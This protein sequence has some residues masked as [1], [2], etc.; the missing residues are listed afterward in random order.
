MV[1]VED[2]RLSQLC[3]QLMPNLHTIHCTTHASIS[4]QLASLCNVLPVTDTPSTNAYHLASHRCRIV[5]FSEQHA[6]K[7]ENKHSQF[8]N[9]NILGGLISK[10]S[11]VKS[12]LIV[13]EYG[14]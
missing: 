10:I 7:S 8:F 14:V 11:K 6:R 12:Y 2:G 5:A 13:L 9:P 3:L 1:R 4:F